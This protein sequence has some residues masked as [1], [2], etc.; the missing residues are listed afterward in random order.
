MKNRIYQGMLAFVL[1]LAM[2]VMGGCGASKDAGGDSEGTEA[3]KEENEKKEEDKKEEKKGMDIGAEIE[4]QVLAEKDGL[5]ITATG[6]GSDRENEFY[7]NLSV[8]NDSDM[9]YHMEAGYCIVNGYSLWCGM[10]DI[11]PGESEMQLDIRGDIL[12]YMDIGE[13]GEIDFYSLRLLETMEETSSDGEDVYYRPSEEQYANPFIKEEKVTLQTSAYGEMGEPTLPEGKELYNENGIQL[14]MTEADEEDQEDGILSRLFLKN[15]S[16][17]YIDFNSGNS[18]VNDFVLD[19]MYS[20]SL[21]GGD[22]TPPGAVGIYQ[23]VVDPYLMMEAM[24]TEEEVE[25]ESIECTLFIKKE[26][27]SDELGSMPETIAEVSYTYT[28]E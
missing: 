26:V 5:K 7:V 25:I 23:V 12:R 4:E 16:S 3:K 13:I 9:V 2:A 20:T 11:E 1:I 24:N 8:K 28:A 18:S 21:V 14:V 17:D 10:G 19:V 27:W 22:I 15:D 6:L